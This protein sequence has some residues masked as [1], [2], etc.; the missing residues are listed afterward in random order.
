MLLIFSKPAQRVRSLIGDSLSLECRDLLCFHFGYYC[1]S[2]TEVLSVLQ[3]A[4]R[5]ARREDVGPAWWWQ[6]GQQGCPWAAG[7]G[8]AVSEPSP[9]QVLA[10]LHR[11]ENS[12]ATKCL[13]W[14]VGTLLLVPSLSNFLALSS[15]FVWSV[16][17]LQCYRK[18]SREK[19][20]LQPS[21]TGGA[22]GSHHKST[23]L[24]TTTGNSEPV[25]TVAI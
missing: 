12:C 3:R 25:L 23:I 7:A 14:A 21:K 19:T 1:G 22:A 24:E 10:F 18:W 13:A 6:D 4:C 15:S 5:R 16:W 11:K 20:T 17:I 9:A 8:D 2:W